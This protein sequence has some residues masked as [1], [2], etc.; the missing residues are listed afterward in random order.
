MNARP[1]GA[2]LE[3]TLGGKAAIALEEQLL[4]LG[5]ADPANGAE[6]TSHVYPTS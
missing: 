1:V 4:S 2:L 6:I 5:A 3:G